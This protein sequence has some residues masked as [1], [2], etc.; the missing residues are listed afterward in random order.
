MMANRARHVSLG[1]LAPRDMAFPPPTTFWER[2][3]AQHSGQHASSSSVHL[4]T[5]LRSAG[6]SHI[7]NLRSRQMQDMRRLLENEKERE[8]ERQAK[9]M[10]EK[11]PKRK[12]RLY[13]LAM[14]NRERSRVRILR[15]AREHE[16]ALAS[17]M[18][19]LGILR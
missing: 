6:M 5:S 1:H 4:T 10:A 3:W 11:N 15:I 16:L 8:I 18:A 13:R 14:A 17:R 2:E 12:K 19:A 7:A 9:G